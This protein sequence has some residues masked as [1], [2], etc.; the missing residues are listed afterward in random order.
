MSTNTIDEKILSRLYSLEA[1]KEVSRCMN[2]YMLLCDQL[3]ATSNL[4][5]LMELFSIDA[6]WQG[7]GKRYAKIFGRYEG[8]DAISGMFSAYTKEPAHF[9]LNAHFL[10]NQIIDVSLEGKSATG[11]WMLIQ[12]SSFNSG[13]SQL[14]CA[15]I[16]A[17]FVFENDTWLIKE[18]TT[19]NIFSRPMSAPWNNAATLAVPKKETRLKQ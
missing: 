13:K 11:R 1:E 5:E 2:R 7:K 14:S 10:C 17:G 18:F 6:V 3:G 12:P 15:Y 8:R 9:E 4:E 16:S 19:E